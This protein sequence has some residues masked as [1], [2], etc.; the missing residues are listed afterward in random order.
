V[1]IIIAILGTLLIALS[2]LLS[3]I[4]QSGWRRLAEFYRSGRSSKPI[5]W[6]FVSARMGYGSAV[7]PFRAALNLGAD[8]NGVSLSLFP[9]FRLGAPPLFV[10]W[11]HL[12]VESDDT[13]GWMQF[14]FRD[15]PDVVLRLQRPLGQEILAYRLGGQGS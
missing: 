6:R 12:S 11:E 15:A 10:P 14:R 3:A 2:A 1:K 5:R 8:G 7:V 4:S 13:S 9:L